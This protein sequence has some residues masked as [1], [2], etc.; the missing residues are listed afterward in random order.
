VDP[1]HP[2]KISVDLETKG[3]ELLPE[4][5]YSDLKDCKLEDEETENSNETAN[6]SPHNW[7]LIQN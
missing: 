2:H 4:D 1:R 7:G 6:N 5:S 3:N